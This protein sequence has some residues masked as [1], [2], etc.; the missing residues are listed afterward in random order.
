MYSFGGGVR[1]YIKE[2]GLGNNFTSYLQV[3]WIDLSHLDGD[4]DDS[5]LNRM[6]R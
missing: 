1:K 2:K 4:I 3:K 6:M 5:I